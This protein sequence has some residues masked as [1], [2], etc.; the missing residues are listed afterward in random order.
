MRWRQIRK[1]IQLYF[2]DARRRRITPS[3]KDLNS[4]HM[5]LER[6]I[7][8]VCNRHSVARIRVEQEIYDGLQ[9]VGARTSDTHR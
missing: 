7:D 2:R 6:M 8:Y 5:Q 1:Q 3:R 4:T 9:R